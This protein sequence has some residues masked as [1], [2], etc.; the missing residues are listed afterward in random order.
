[1]LHPNASN[2]AK[3]PS[4]NP[5]GAEGFYLNDLACGAV[6]EVATAHHKYRL[7]KGAD[8]H[9]GISGHPTYCPHPIDVEI[10]GSFDRWPPAR[11]KPGFIGCGMHLMFKHP[12]F[13]LVTTST[14]REIHKID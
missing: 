9:V 3:L 1:M 13:D 8:A 5:G 11:P 14:I 4:E 7:V 10:E 2:E 12:V 6:V